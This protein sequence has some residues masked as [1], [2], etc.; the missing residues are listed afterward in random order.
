MAFITN[1][2]KDGATTLAKR[3][4]E[5][6]GH[7]DQLDMLVGFFYFSGV[8]L[9]DTCAAGNL[10][11]IAPINWPYQSAEKP[12]TRDAAQVLNRIAQL[13]AGDGAVEVN[14]KGAVMSGVDAKVASAVSGRGRD[15]NEYH[16]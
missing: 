10:L 16:N 9:F 8:K 4:A 6:I 11:M 7:A 3:L 14:Y 15:M 1:Q 5:L 13:I 2:N 12:M